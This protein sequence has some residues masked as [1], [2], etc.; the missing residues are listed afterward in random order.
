MPQRM[1]RHHKGVCVC[2]FGGATFKSMKSA[3]CITQLHYA[4]K[5]HFASSCAFGRPH[6]TQID[7]IIQIFTAEAPH[8]QSLPWF[9]SSNRSVVAQVHLLEHTREPP[10]SDGPEEQH[11]RETLCS[12]TW[13]CKTFK[14]ME[15]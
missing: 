5:H 8:R 1:H 6:H 13:H 10:N 12:D 4:Q 9:S 3:A 2:D 7:I 11:D 15:G 14:M